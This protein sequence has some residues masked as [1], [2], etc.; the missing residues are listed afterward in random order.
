MAVVTEQDSKLAGANRSGRSSE[1]PRQLSPAAPTFVRTFLWAVA[2]ALLLWAAFPP[3][4]IPWLA[5]LA[6]LPWLWLVAQ[7]QLAGRRA[8]VAIWLA[9]GVH[10]LLMLQGIRL[11]HPALYGG[12]IALALYVAVYLPLFIGL[13]RVAVHRC[14]VSLVVAA[15]V[16]W[17]GLELIRGHLITGFSMGLLA[18]TQA[19]LPAL[20][21][22]SDVAGGY[23]LSFVIMLVAA[24]LLRAIPGSSRRMTIWPLAVAAGAIGVTVGYGRWRLSQI[25]PGAAGPTANIALIQGSLDTVFD[26]TP[27]RVFETFEHYRGLTT[28]AA[29][30]RPNLDLVVWPESSFLANEH[31]LADDFVPESD[32]LL[33]PAEIHRRLVEAGRNFREL[34]A[35]EV[36]R[37]NQQTEAG[38][39]G[40]KLVVN[41]TTF[42]HGAGGVRVYNAALLAEGDGLVTSRYYKTH[43]VMFGEYIPFGDRFPWLYRVTPLGGGLS[44]GDGPK[45]F[46]VAGLRM[47]P[48]ICFE[49]TI[50]HLIRGQLAELSRR[51][52]PADC[53]LNVT[54]DGWF[55][56]TAILDLHLRCGIFRAVENRRPLLI[57]ANT[58]ISAAI[59]G[60]GVVKTRG[61]KRQP[62]VLVATVR[63]DGRPYLYAAV[64][65]LPAGLCA[66][67]C[68]VVAIAA[69]LAKVRKAPKLP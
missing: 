31:L 69:G 57:A 52:T 48:S 12:W 68:V 66:S 34:L 24:G 44:I 62:Q 8:Y 63:A 3:I 47:S 33:E 65:D 59:D 23:G 41:T 1:Q 58:G 67:L 39:A 64:G 27:D 36:R 55:W 5:W 6:P 50:P 7:P 60:S 13:T 18:H 11:A 29:S 10:W 49:S 20:I 22:I 32:G 15:P 45:V 19:E 25:P 2:G 16:V 26:I 28:E 40:T 37:A 43:P 46:E 30:E 51:G 56:G 54:N 53:L 21:Q 61:K 14:G 9:G 42:V 4:D 17:V 38:R 35:A